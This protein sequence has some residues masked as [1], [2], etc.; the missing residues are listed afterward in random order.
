MTLKLRKKQHTKLNP[1]SR[2]QLLQVE[3]FYHVRQSSISSSRVEHMSKGPLIK[4]TL[5]ASQGKF[6]AH[7]NKVASD[8]I[9]AHV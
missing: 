4:Q 2:K 5:T 6:P 7:R 3:R 9:L 8:E 1:L